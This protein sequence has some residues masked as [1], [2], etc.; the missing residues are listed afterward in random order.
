MISDNPNDP[1]E[2]SQIEVYSETKDNAYYDLL[3][4]YGNY[5]RSDKS[6]KGRSVYV[7]DFDDGK[8]S[9][10][11]NSI[12]KFWILGRSSETYK[13]GEKG[14]AR[15]DFNLELFLKFVPPPSQVFS[16][17]SPKKRKR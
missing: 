7:S 8:Y 6:R 5:S 1:E 2:V 16:L 17:N 3:H 11:W 14:Y 13:E 10:W 12:G 9:I 4:I 15:Y